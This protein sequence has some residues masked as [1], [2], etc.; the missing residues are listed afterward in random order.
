[1]EPIFQLCERATPAVRARQPESHWSVP[2]EGPASPQSSR[3]PRQ[4]VLTFHSPQLLRSG[5]QPEA[6]AARVN[7]ASDITCHPLKP[8]LMMVPILFC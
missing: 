5:V 7:N 3:C 8:K 1:M 4:Q 2:P 6:A